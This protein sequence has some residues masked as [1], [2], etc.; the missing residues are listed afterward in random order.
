MVSQDVTF[1][2]HFKSALATTHRPFQGAQFVRPD[3]IDKA[4]ADSDNAK[5]TYYFDEILDHSQTKN[6]QYKFQVH[7]RE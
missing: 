1:D 2:E 3:P 4:A 7:R 6:G 5:P